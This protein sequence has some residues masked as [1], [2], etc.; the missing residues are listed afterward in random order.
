MAEKP[1]DWVKAK[2]LRIPAW[3]YPGFNN[4]IGDKFGL[5]YNF[6]ASSALGHDDAMRMEIREGDLVKVA[7]GVV[8]CNGGLAYVT[9]NF[10]E[11]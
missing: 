11:P 8:R 9:I 1:E 5:L 6:Y 3:C 4:I 10:T 7:I 2:K